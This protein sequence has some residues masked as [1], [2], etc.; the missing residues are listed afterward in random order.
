MKQSLALNLGQLNDA[1]QD[2]VTPYKHPQTTRGPT[3]SQ[4]F[5]PDEQR[6]RNLSPIEEKRQGAQSARGNFK[7]MKERLQSSQSKKL[8]TPTPAIPTI[9][10]RSQKF[11]SILCPYCNRKFSEKA[12]SR[13]IAYCKEKAELQKFKEG[14]PK[15]KI[16]KPTTVAPCNADVVS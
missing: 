15:T 10:E 2:Y 16:P 6:G 11:S 7:S 14:T 1:N 3:S 5:S 12:G 9:Y 8:A 13:H 4:M